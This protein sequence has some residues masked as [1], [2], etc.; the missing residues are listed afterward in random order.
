MATFVHAP[1][2]DRRDL[3]ART[4]VAGA[5]ARPR[6]STPVFFVAGLVGIRSED[7]IDELPAPTSTVVERRKYEKKRVVWQALRAGLGL[8]PRLIPR[9]PEE[10]LMTAWTQVAQPSDRA[11]L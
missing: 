11:K 3:V 6:P 1:Q 2:A 4:W 5:P 7:A 10:R 9:T 8:G